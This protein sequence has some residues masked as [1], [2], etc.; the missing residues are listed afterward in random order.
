M[1]QHCVNGYFTFN[2]HLHFSGR[3]VNTSYRTEQLLS[4]AKAKLD[5]T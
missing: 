1:K 3:N 5:L 4:V 2:G